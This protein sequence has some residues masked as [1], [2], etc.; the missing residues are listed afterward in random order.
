M[1]VKIQKI[2]KQIDISLLEKLD[3]FIE[4]NYIPPESV[5][6]DAKFLPRNITERYYNEKPGDKKHI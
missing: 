2:S 5:P 3:K 6:T 1:P 4:E